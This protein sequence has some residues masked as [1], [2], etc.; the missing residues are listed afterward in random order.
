MAPTSC[1]G[2]LGGTDATC[3]VSKGGLYMLF[4]AT[5]LAW[6]GSRQ[7]LKRATQSP[8]DAPLQAETCHVLRQAIDL[9]A[10]QQTHA[11][12]TC[13]RAH[14]AFPAD[15]QVEAD[16]LV[17][18]TKFGTDAE[19]A[20]VLDWAEEQPSAVR[21]LAACEAADFVWLDGQAARASHELA[22]LGES[23]A[24]AARCDW[25]AAVDGG[26]YAAASQHVES[27]R[28]RGGSAGLANHMETRT[29]S[30]QR[31]DLLMLGFFLTLFVG[32]PAFLAWLGGFAFIFLAGG[33]L[34]RRALEAAEA[35]PE[36][37]TGEAIGVS[38][39]L[40]SRYRSLLRFA[41]LYYYLSVPIVVVGVLLIALC[42]LAAVLYIGL[43]PIKLLVIVG[44]V[45]LGG[46][47]AMLKGL[48]VRPPREDPGTELELQEH[49]RLR[50]VLDEVAERVGTR[51]VDTV[52]L[53]PGVDIAV[54]EDSTTVQ[55]L[56]GADAR[57]CLVLGLGVL[58]GM[59]LGWF[60]SILAHEYGHFSNRDTADGG[61][62]LAV[63]RSLWLTIME[64]AQGGSA[65]EW[66]PTWQFVRLYWQLFLRVSHGASRLQEV[67]ADRWAASCYGSEAFVKG[68]THVIRREASF[69]AHVH[70]SVNECLERDL[71]LPNLYRFAP[72]SPI[73]DDE[74][75][76]A[77]QQAM[78][79]E[80][81]PYDSHPPPADR[82]RWVEAMAR[83]VEPSTEDAGPALELLGV[84]PRL[85]EEMTAQVRMNLAMSH[86]V[87]LRER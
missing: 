58:E 35:A 65:A 18:R 12:E 6:G 45:V 70:A 26:D 31:G 53:T 74:I 15:E 72:S 36:L 59:E 64:M 83:V 46:I 38:A 20:A 67:L 14:F 78:A 10:E 24:E 42:G 63:R 13:E 76:A 21:W 82:L 47:A 43:I 27:F 28:Q 80:A 33:A 56:R 3:E 11:L 44:V 66:N 79:A 1:C 77:F 30:I 40:R 34:S 55:A 9:E 86:G 81:D 2:G 54:F 22:L 73:A 51:P 52:Y 17:V 41:G 71:A 75:E 23:S 5:T 39:S 16:L 7:A 57:R 19:G 50:E 4:L 8:D 62:A 61:L 84:L 25:I 60:K 48:F 69:G 37:S 68:F 32:A 49:P 29:G 87:L 85:E